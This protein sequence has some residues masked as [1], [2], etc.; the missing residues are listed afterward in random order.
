MVKR[1]VVSESE[2]AGVAVTPKACVR[3]GTLSHSLTHSEVH[4]HVHKSPPLVPFLS[5][6]HPIHTIPSCL[7]KIHFNIVHPPTSWFSQ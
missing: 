6:I 5:Q 7:S 3:V 4:Y 2:Q 1:L